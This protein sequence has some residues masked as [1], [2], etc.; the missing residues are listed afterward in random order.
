MSAVS[1]KAV[2]AGITV[3]IGVVWGSILLAG[4]GES[5]EREPGGPVES[6]RGDDTVEYTVPDGATAADVARDLEI[7]GVIRSSRQFESLVRLMGVQN[8]LSAG[9]HILFLNSSAAEVVDVLLVRPGL[10]QVEITFPEGIRIEEM[11]AIVQAADVGVLAEQFIFAAERAQLPPGLAASLPPAEVLPSGQRL[12]GYLFPDTYFV[13]EET[14]AA[15][16]VR[17]MVEQM[18]EEF[19]ATMRET[20]AERGLT[21][22]EVLT[23]AS[24]VE[25]EAVL[26]EER[27]RIAAVFFNRLE[28]GDLI[29]A[30]PT[31]QYA[32]SLDP[33]SVKEWGYWKDEL[34]FDDLQTDSPYNTRLYPGMPPGPITNPGLQS[35]LAVLE[36]EETDYYYFV[37]NSVEGDGS[38]VFAVTAEEHDLNKVIYGAQ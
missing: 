35:I 5:L 20:A 6:T 8:N 31:T 23:L 3:T 16:L 2:V 1:W 32:V 26:D 15:E 12:Q 22:H 18:N 10:P 21:V 17:R 30:D 36:P 9:Q 25:R 13:T 11:G 28:A 27:P 37:A 38:H 34:T 33:D 24:I 4:S 14:T 19:T 7:L 29:G